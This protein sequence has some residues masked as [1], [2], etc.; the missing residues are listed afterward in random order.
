MNKTVAIAALV[1]AVIVVLAVI[2]FTGNEKTAPNNTNKATTTQNEVAT[3]SGQNTNT[4]ATTTPMNAVVL[5][6]VESGSMITVSQATL[7]KPGYVVLYLTTSQGESSVVGNSSLL[8]AG[9]HSN[10]KIQLDTPAADR[11]AIVS[12]LHT[13]DGDG[14]FEYPETDS[15]L[16]NAA[17]IVV[18]DIDVVGVSRT[19]SESQILEKQVKTYI[20]NNFDA[21]A[22]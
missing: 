22:N 5:G 12:V 9:T 18:N 7:T 16:M 10:I 20:E 21:E 17:G 15:Y 14:K 19:E 4:Q 6:E 11:Q 2:V 8:Q 1:V 3:T 13:D